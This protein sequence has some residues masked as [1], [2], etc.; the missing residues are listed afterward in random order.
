MARA[1]AARFFIPA[2]ELRRHVVFVAIEADFVQFQAN[3]DFEVAGS[4]S[5]CFV[6][7]QSDIFADS[8][9]AEERTALEGNADVLAQFAPLSGREIL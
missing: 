5:V 9:G 7:W 1:T 6:E 8:H 2:A 4:R 3:H